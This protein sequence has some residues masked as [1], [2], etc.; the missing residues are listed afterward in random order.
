MNT[1]APKYADWTPDAAAFAS[2]ELAMQ[3]EHTRNFFGANIE[4]STADRIGSAW[5]DSSAKQR[6]IVGRRDR[7]R[8]GLGAGGCW[9][10]GAGAWRWSWSGG[11]RQARARRSSRRRC[12]WALRHRKRRGSRLHLRRGA[13]LASVPQE[14]SAARL[15]SR[16][17]LAASVPIRSVLLRR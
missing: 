16:S 6:M 3:Q 14:R 13:L 9:S 8:H 12:L 2:K 7:W 11:R 5:G 1:E 17:W 10:A 15:A 4:Q